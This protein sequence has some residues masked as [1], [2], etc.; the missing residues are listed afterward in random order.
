LSELDGLFEFELFEF[1]GGRW[2][3]S[4]RFLA[5]VRKAQKKAEELYPW[6]RLIFRFDNAPNHRK[7]G[8]DA[9]NARFMNVRS[10]GNQ[11]VMHPTVWGDGFV[12]LIKMELRKD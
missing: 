1:G 11:R 8:N 10:G 3:N 2:W 7:Y 6:A 12:W 9:L 4:D 5:H